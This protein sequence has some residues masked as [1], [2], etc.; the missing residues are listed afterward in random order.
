M[1]VFQLR[2]IDALS[3]RN[4]CLGHFGILQRYSGRNSVYKIVRIIKLGK[5]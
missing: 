2:F 5:R 4:T 1:E 3:L